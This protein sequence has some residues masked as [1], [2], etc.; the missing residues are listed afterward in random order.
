[1]YGM[2]IEH[3]RFRSG[4]RGISET[5]FIEFISSGAATGREQLFGD[6]EAQDIDGNLI[7]LS[8]YDGRVS[9]VINVASEWKY[10][11][12]HYPQLQ[13]FYK[14]YNNIGLSILAFPSNEFGEQEPDS[15]ELIKQKVS[16]LFGITFD[17]FSKI[18]VNGDNA[19]PLYSWLKETDVG[20]GNDVEWNFESF[21]I[22]RCGKVHARHESDE[23][24]ETWE[25]EIVALLQ[26]S[27]L[28]K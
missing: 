14:K 17:M 15:N 16:D 20:G 13:E 28:C 27:T 7:Q 18:E 6:F 23:Q 4:L 21:I 19:L 5:I 26:D 8:D 3:R 12:T 10:T 24:P 2:T 9:I 25:D 1:M 11:G 22:D